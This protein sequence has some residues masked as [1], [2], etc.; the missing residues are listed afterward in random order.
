MGPNL[1]GVMGRRAGSKP[2]YAYSDAMKTS[3]VVWNEASLKSFVMDPNAVVPA[4]NMMFAAIKSPAQADDVVAYL[5]T[6]Q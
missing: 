6:L 4:A 3:G 2:R 1:F 5:A